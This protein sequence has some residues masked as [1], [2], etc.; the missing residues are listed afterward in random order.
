[1]GKFEEL[2]EPT[3]RT[4]Q[5]SSALSSGQDPT[6]GY[7]CGGANDTDRTTVAKL[8]K[9][10][11]IQWRNHRGKDKEDHGPDRKYRSTADDYQVY[12]MSPHA[13]D[14]RPLQSCMSIIPN[15]T[16]I[17]R[18]EPRRS[19]VASGHRKRVKPIMPPVRCPISRLSRRG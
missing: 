17:S 8:S 4:A 10:R 6:N 5:P 13:F 11:G 3:V 9:D 14:P 16:A 19:A 12:S 2:P 15:A 1:M 7:T 18:E